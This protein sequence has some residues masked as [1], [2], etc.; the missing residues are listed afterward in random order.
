MVVM[1]LDIDSLSFQDKLFAKGSKSYLY[2]GEFLNK[3]TV[4]KE[5]KPKAYRIKEIDDELRLTRMRLEARIIKTLLR[6]NEPVPTL[7]GIDLNKRQLILEYLDGQHL[8]KF[9]EEDHLFFQLGRQIARLHTLHI[10]HSDLSHLNV[11][12]SKEKALYL[13]DFGLAYFFEEMKD[14]VMDLF[15]FQG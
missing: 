4:I 15:I 8:S 2:L 6:N 5:R 3:K 9:I 10:I 7:Y 14:K 11:I 13:I 1:S 12:I